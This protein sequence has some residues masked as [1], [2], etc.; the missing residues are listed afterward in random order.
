MDVKIFMLQNELFKEGIGIEATQLNSIVRKW[1]ILTKD[2]PIDYFKPNIRVTKEQLEEV[3]TECKF[4]RKETAK[5]M[6]IS[7]RN[8]YRYLKRFGLNY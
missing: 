6:D 7:E 1:D 4:N 8:L 2:T 5:R 3:L